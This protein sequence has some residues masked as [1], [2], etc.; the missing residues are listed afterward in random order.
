MPSLPEVPV[1]EAANGFS[2]LK[3]E[4]QKL[5]NKMFSK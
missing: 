5:G 1:Y 3:W 4:N 2:V